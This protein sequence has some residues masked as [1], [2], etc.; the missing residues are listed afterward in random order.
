MNKTQAERLNSPLQVVA[1]LHSS[2]QMMRAGCANC[3][4][5]FSAIAESLREHS[6]AEELQSSGLWTNPGNPE[7]E[8]EAPDCGEPLVDR[9]LPPAPPCRMHAQTL[10]A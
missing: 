6:S 10:C 9:A 5:Q 8:G 1:E 7:T 2:I 3:T 4:P